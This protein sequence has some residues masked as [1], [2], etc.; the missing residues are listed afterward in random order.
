MNNRQR[1]TVLT[2]AIVFSL[3]S[4]VWA[5]TSP[6]GQLKPTL[7]SIIDVI[8]DD[9]FKG[10]GRKNVR[11]QKIMAHVDKGFDFEEMSRRVLG[12]TWLDLSAV[13]Q[14][15]FIEQF[16]KLLEN[17]YI[18]KLEAYGGEQIQY[19]DEKI[20]GDRAM[21]TTIVPGQTKGLPVNYIMIDKGGDWMVYDLKIEGIGLIKNY[22]EQFKS[23][24]KRNDFQGLIKELEK[25]NK[26]FQ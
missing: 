13:D 16:T 23:I 19:L 5:V 21:V 8:I 4:V 7:Q 26:S 25:K 22:R 10:E 2:C 17:V 14:G 20:K 9:S 24:L 15:R 3:V 18:G 1:I 11:R 12:R 6:T